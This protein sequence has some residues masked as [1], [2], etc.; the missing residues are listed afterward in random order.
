MDQGCEERGPAL[1]L[2]SGR[3]LLVIIGAVR[4]SSKT[5][6]QRPCV[7]KL[8]VNTEVGARRESQ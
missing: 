8:T 6:G 5:T 2:S 7:Q 3:G 1:F 4:F